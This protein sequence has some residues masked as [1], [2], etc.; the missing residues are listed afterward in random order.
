MIMI[1][2]MIIIIV[3]VLDDDDTYWVLLLGLLDTPTIH[4]KFIT[5]H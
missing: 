1:M 4:F 5:K 3:V 2:I